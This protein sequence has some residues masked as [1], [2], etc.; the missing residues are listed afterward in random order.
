MSGEHDVRQGSSSARTGDEPDGW[1]AV[2]EVMGTFGSRGE[3]RVKPLGRYPERFRELSTVYVGDEHK[4][5]RVV[6]RRSYGP[7]IV[8]RVE[9]VDSRDDARILHGKYLFVPESEA[10]KL[11]AGEY[12]IHQVVGLRVV[13]MD[14]E[15]LG[16]LSD[17]LQ[18]G[19]NDVYVVKGREREILLP[20]IKDVVKRIDL[21]SGTIEVT[22]LPGLLD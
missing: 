22:L 3:L 12:F 5:V 15:E 9:N 14:G 2:G 20:A 19:S 4:P 10:V 21:E 6:H 17:V 16:T 13:T 1:I 7:G 8:M 11:P 18:T